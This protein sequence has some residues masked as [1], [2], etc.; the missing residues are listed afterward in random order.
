[1]AMKDFAVTAPRPLPV[2]ILADTSGSLGVDGKIEALNQSLRDMVKSFPTESRLRAEI[3]L[4]VNTFGGDAQAH[5]PLS[6]A[7]QI[8]GIQEFVASGGTPLARRYPK[9]IN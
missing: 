4:G 9:P 2:F 5:L 3:H 1:M 6:A 7:H 8:Q